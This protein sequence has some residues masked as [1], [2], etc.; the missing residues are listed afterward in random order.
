MT[1]MTDILMRGQTFLRFHGFFVSRFLT[2][3]ES[4]R[5]GF[6]CFIRQD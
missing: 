2:A 3:C 4:R 5:Y 6:L 1:H